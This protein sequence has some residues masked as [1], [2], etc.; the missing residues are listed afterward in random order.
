MAKLYKFDTRTQPITRYEWEDGVW[1]PE[2]L[3]AN[4]TISQDADG[5]IVIVST[6]S[7]YSE[8]ERYAPTPDTT[9]DPSLYS[10]VS[11]TYVDSSGQTLNKEPKGERS[12]EA[13]EV[14][15]GKGRD[16]MEGGS[17]R[18]HLFGD[19]GDDT[20]DGGAGDD[21]LAG[22]AGNDTL[23]GG[24]GN[25][26]VTYA[27]APQ[28]VVASLS[29]GRGEGRHREATVGQDKLISIENLVG[30][31]FDDKLVGSNQDNRLDGGQGA[32]VIVGGGGADLLTGGLGA[33]VFVYLSAKDSGLGVKADVI[34]DFQPGDKIDLSAI[35]AKQGF[36]RNDAFTWL[37]AA[38]TA[39]NANGALWFDA[40]TGTLYGSTDRDVE[41]EFAIVLTG[42]T[43][44]TA[45]DVVL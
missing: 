30:S 22:G 24:E 43:S 38:P 41:P 39:L 34:T 8:V 36:S 18:D 5:S 7:K 42:V 16:H 9:D 33:D 13:P 21:T 23:N 17:G 40:A 12:P 1:K 19:D 45:D 10:K 26:T 37:D 14:H 29:G 11:E 15:G 20:V 25:D 27:D 3:K 35:D 4:Q 2:P 32:D 28:G 6:Y 44:L 31:A